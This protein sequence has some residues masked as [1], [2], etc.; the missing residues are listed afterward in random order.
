MGAFAYQAIDA[1]GKKTVGMVDAPDSISATRTLRSKGLTV[2]KL[3]E[4]GKV[5]K[6]QGD[7]SIPLLSGRVKAKD[8]T[9]FSRQFAT[10][11][12]SGLTILRSLMILEEQV[13]SKALKKIISEIASDIEGGRSLSE[14]MEK[15]PR[16]FD[17]LFV[18]MVRA[19][20]VGGVLEMTLQRVASYMEAREAL[21]RKVKSAMTYP[22]V[23]LVFALLAAIGM[24]LFLVPIFTK[25]YED[26][27]SELPAIT[28]FLVTL[29]D[30]GKSKPFLIPIPILTPIFLFKFWVG[31]ETGRRQ[32]D[33]IKL[34][35]PMKVGGIVQKVSLARFSRTLSSLIASGVPMMQ[36]VQVT[37][38]TSG[39]SVIEDAMADIIRSIEEGRTFSEPLKRHPIFPSMVI[40]MAAIGEET[41]QM[42]AMLEKVAEFYEDEVDAAIKS[43]TSIVEPIMMIFVGAI[44]GFIIIALYMPMFALFDKIK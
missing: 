17:R 39:N 24:I 7:L 25:M 29:S 11:I 13:Q 30:N 1:T 9:L 10:M 14:S 33:R 42:D 20:E 12:G 32:W 2:V 41:G 26:L 35:L 31:R 38:D 21:K 15:H 43:L 18:S 36:A 5:S 28:K 37:G 23:V 27:D 34:R 4:G 8:L 16:A 19:G 22:T 6:T 3:T 40:Q 44:V